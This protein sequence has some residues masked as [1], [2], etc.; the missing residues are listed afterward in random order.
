MRWRHRFAS[1]RARL[2]GGGGALLFL[3]LLCIALFLCRGAW[4]PAACGK[5]DALDG[6]ANKLGEVLP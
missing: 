5:T 4:T 2:W 3:S 1:R 6:I